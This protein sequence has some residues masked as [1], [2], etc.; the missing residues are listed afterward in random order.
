MA[1]EKCKLMRI[2]E[3][4]SRVVSIGVRKLLG[5]LDHFLESSVSF[6]NGLSF[7]CIVHNFD[8]VDSFSDGFNPI[9]EV[10]YLRIEFG[11]IQLQLFA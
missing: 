9:S 7:C 8:I 11:Y 1:Y 2:K 5:L 10:P 6:D 4:G 3:T